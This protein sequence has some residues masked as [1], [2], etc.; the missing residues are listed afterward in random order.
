M[1]KQRALIKKF[2]NGSDLV[3]S[4]D[5]FKNDKMSCRELL[6]KRIPKKRKGKKPNAEVLPE[7]LAYQ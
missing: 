5:E 3:D 1:R 4:L 2:W 6:N 7:E